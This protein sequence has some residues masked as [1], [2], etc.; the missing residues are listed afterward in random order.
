M[1]IVT[2]CPSC[3]RKYDVAARL[4]GKKV[5]CQDCA[6]TF[7]VPVPPSLPSEA[8]P[9]GHSAAP[10]ILNAGLPRAATP[11]SRARGSLRP[12]LIVGFLLTILAML[13]FWFVNR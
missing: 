2:T 10:S 11:R 1:I 3:G 12:A 8:R 7:R 9:E 6:T 13:T 4:A 5:R